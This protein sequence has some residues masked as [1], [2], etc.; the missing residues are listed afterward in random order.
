MKNRTVYNLGFDS[1]PHLLLFF[2]G[3]AIRI[4]FFI[5]F[6]ASS[7]GRHLSGPGSPGLFSLGSFGKKKIPYTRDSIS[8]PVLPALRAS[9]GRPAL[10]FYSQGV[11]RFPNSPLLAVGEKFVEGS[12]E[13][14]SPLPLLPPE[15]IFAC[16]PWLHRWTPLLLL[17]LR[18]NR[19]LLPQPSSQRNEEGSVAERGE[20]AGG[21]R[22]G[23]GGMPGIP[24]GNHVSAVRP[25]NH[26]SIDGV[27]RRPKLL[28]VGERRQ[29]YAG[30]KGEKMWFRVLLPP[31]C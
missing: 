4:S 28:D 16:V 5:F 14:R 9:Y 22:D 25:D 1:L 17:L 30:N 20:R 11:R 31:S 10:L 2:N 3:F 13:V 12:L 18:W 29:K 6:V 21:V 15:H 7:L 8:R 24:D 27:P 23:G 26:M 19:V